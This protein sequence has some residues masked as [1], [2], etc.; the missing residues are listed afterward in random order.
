MSDERVFWVMEKKDL[1]GD[2]SRWLVRGRAYTALEVGKAVWAETARG[3]VPLVIVEMS[4]YGRALPFL[5]E[6]MT[7]DMIVTG[8]AGD[9]LT[10]VEYLLMPEQVS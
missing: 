8:H 5:G 6:T 4:S 10:G 9:D 7:G 1:T 2:G 3:R